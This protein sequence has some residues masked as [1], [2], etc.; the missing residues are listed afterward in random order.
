[1]TAKIVKVEKSAYCE[2]LRENVVIEIE[3]AY[4]AENL[5]DYAPRILAKRCVRAVECNGDERSSCIFCGT[6]PNFNPTE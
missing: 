2:R 4:A 3:M 6:N 1:M 5:P